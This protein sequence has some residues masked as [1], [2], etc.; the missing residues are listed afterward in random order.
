MYKIENSYSI[1]GKDYDGLRTI[2]A[3]KINELPSGKL[4]VYSDDFDSNNYYIDTE[5]KLNDGV[6][7]NQSTLDSNRAIRIYK[8]WPEAWHYE[9]K[10]AELVYKLQQKQKCV[11]LTDFPTGIVTIS[12][13]PF[14]YNK[15][16]IQRVIGQEIIYY[17]NYI[18]IGKL[19]QINHNINTAKIYI[20]IIKI[21]K[22]LLDNGIYYG[23]IHGGNFV[24]EKEKQIVKLIDFEDNKVKIDNIGINEIKTTFEVLKRLIIGLDVYSKDSLSSNIAKTNN[25]DELDECLNEINQKKKKLN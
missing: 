14:E 16:N 17:E 25:L 9:K 18:A 5:F 19:F 22:E 12:D 13:F 4:L 6:I 10:D 1:N 21:L 2:S 15:K 24:I 11:K 20:D 8:D 7:I 23:D 3:N